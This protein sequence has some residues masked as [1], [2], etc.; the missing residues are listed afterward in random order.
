VAPTI[1]FSSQVLLT[2]QFLLKF[3]EHLE[4]YGC[5]SNK[6]H[7]LGIETPELE[8]SDPVLLPRSLLATQTVKKIRCGWNFSFFLTSM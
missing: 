2:S 5:G 3:L 8:V 6:S 1:L 7:S 4:I